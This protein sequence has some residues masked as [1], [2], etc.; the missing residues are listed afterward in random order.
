MVDTAVSIGAPYSMSICRP[1]ISNLMSILLTKI[2]QKKM[3]VVKP[4]IDAGKYPKEWDINF[5]KGIGPSV[6]FLTQFDE[7]ITRRIYGYKTVGCYYRH[8]SPVNKM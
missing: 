1:Y 3:K 2:L 7:E 5:E 8:F 6:W 4:I